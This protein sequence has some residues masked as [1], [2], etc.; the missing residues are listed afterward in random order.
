MNRNELKALV[1][2]YSKPINA[3]D[4][5]KKHIEIIPQPGEGRS[6]TINNNEIC[7]VKYELEN[8]LLKWIKEEK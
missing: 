8:G 5:Y 1:K 6:I 3:M 2:K 7:I 4:L